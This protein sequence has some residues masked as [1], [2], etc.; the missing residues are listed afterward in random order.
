ME[1][2]NEHERSSET[3]RTVREGGRNNLSCISSKVVQV[4]Y[5]QL[6]SAEEAWSV[7]AQ[8]GRRGS[9]LQSDTKVS[10]VAFEEAKR[11][12]DRIIREKTGKGYRIAQSVVALLL[13]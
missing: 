3:V 11:V 6:R 4:Y 9:A 1:N 8:C 13:S 2:R 10:S 12:Y 5:L 7:H